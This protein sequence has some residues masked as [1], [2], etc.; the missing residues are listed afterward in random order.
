LVGALLD[1]GVDP[2][3]ENKAAWAQHWGG[4]FTAL[5]GAIQDGHL[6]VV[7]LLL[8]RGA[9]GDCRATYDNSK[10]TGTAL[11]VAIHME[12][13]EIA[14]LL[15]E[16]GADPN[17]VDGW[18]E[19]TPLH[20]A[21][22]AGDLQTA[23]ALLEHG[24]DTEA[25]AEGWVLFDR[26]ES[27]HL[28]LTPLMTAA[29]SGHHDVARLLLE[30][31]ASLDACSAAVLGLLDPL[32][33]MLAADPGQ[34][35]ERL[36]PGG[37]TLLHLAARFGRIEVV[38]HLLGKGLDI[39][40][41]A[42]E[43][44][45]EMFQGPLVHLYLNPDGADFTDPDLGQADL[46][47]GVTPLHLAVEARRT[48]LI[49]QLVAWGADIDALNGRSNVLSR[50]IEAER[51]D[52]AALLLS[53]GADAARSS[54]P[55]L[56]AAEKNDVRALRLL[57]DHWEDSPERRVEV[58]AA[59]EKAARWRSRE[60]AALLRAEGGE[61]TFLSAC[62]LGDVEYVQSALEE[63]PALARTVEMGLYSRSPLWL[64]A[65]LGSV[66]ILELVCAALEEA[67]SAPDLSLALHSA[68]RHGYPEAVEWL[69]ARGAPIDCRTDLGDTPLH[70]AAWGDSPEVIRL[71]VANGADLEEGGEAGATPL[72]D[73]AGQ[74]S[75]AAIE[76]LLELGADLEAR[77]S[78]GETPLHWAAVLG[79]HDAVARLLEKGANV[80]ARNHRQQTPLFHVEW[81]RMTFIE[82]K[83]AR[84][85]LARLL[86]D[87]GGVR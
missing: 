63:R 80:N 36:P 81:R 39:D 64:A 27:E 8:E 25:R 53:L 5:T 69:L 60:A 43:I 68:A 13:P 76:T 52:L 50:A 30:E 31:G 4:G 75:L 3:S 34:L 37:E 48:D 83:E 6:D 1:E 28:G 32:S 65:E 11:H 51:F 78:D 41:R 57:L 18:A 77:K 44:G 22:L 67:S 54:Y 14:C 66:E 45:W 84:R 72:H 38:S 2:S 9:S 74:G 82:D 16:H 70:M 71:L 26:D 62:M 85:A 42:P 35:R 15:L 10:N 79:E 24:A 46:E 12:E 55:L 58:S 56:L 73:A 17:G 49:R 21:A 20:V 59:L 40:V 23:R 47:R 7:R 29:G 19:A 33:E 87:A 61:L 86:R